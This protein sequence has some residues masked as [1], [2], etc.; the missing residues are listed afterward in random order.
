ME[1]FA[2]QIVNDLMLFQGLWLFSGCK[3]SPL[4]GERYFGSNHQ[5]CPKNLSSKSLKNKLIVKSWFFKLK[6]R[7]LQLYKKWASSRVLQGFWLHLLLT[8]LQRAIFKLEV[9]L[10]LDLPSP[11]L[12]L[13]DPLILKYF[14]PPSPTSNPCNPLTM[15]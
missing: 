14:Q 12:Y 5:G 10:F 9:L 3:F 1:L 6:S 15:F 4:Q 13:T 11:P 8:A 2:K 7:N